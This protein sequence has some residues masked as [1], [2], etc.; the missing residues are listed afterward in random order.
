MGKIDRVELIARSHQD[1]IGFERDLL[2]VRR[3]Q[4]EIRRRQRP[5]EPIPDP[6]AANGH[7]AFL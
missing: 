6:R 7:D 3:E 2:E 5:Q 1:G 4:G